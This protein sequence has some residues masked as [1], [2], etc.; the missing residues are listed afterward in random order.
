MTKDKQRPTTNNDQ[1]QTTTKDKQRPSTN[2][3]QGQTATNNKQRPTI[4]IIQMDRSLAKD[5]PD[6]PASCQ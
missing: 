6:K 1:Q 2:N 5:H 3:D 4:N